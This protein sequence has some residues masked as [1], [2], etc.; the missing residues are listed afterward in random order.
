MTWTDKDI[1]ILIKTSTFSNPAHK[2]ALR[3]KLFEPVIEL[4][5]DDLNAAAGGLTLADSTS[6]EIWQIWDENKK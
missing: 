6:P 4:D 3:E 2:K 5:P 1:E